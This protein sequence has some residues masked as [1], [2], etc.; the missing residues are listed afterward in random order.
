MRAVVGA[1]K[2][3]AADHRPTGLIVVNVGRVDHCDIEVRIPGNQAGG[4]GNPCCSAT[5]DDDVKG[6]VGL[7]R[8]RF[9]AI[10]DAPR[11][12]GHVIPGGIGSREDVGDRL[13]AG[14]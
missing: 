10:G 13:F 2:T 4:N 1:S 12:S 3:P 5:H 14:L 11:H 8:R 7:F 6:S 9:A